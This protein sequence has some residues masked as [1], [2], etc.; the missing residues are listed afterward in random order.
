MKGGWS[1][2]TVENPGTMLVTYAAPSEPFDDEF[3]MKLWNSVS[4]SYLDRP[5]NAGEVVAMFD[6]GEF[7]PIANPTVIFT[8]P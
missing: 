4:T 5:Y 2:G 7:Q 1:V 3:G 6:A 8:K